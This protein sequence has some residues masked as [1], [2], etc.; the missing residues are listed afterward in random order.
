MGLLSDEFGPGV[1]PR[2]RRRTTVR[3]Y[4]IGPSGGQV[5]TLMI[6]AA[7]GGAV[8]MY[9]VPQ[10][11]SL[12]MGLFKGTETPKSVIEKVKIAANQKRNNTSTK[13]Q[14][15]TTKPKPQQ[16]QPQATMNLRRSNYTY[17]TRLPPLY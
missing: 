3:H 17:Y 13:P 16:Q 14:Q 8:A 9:Y 10:L 12:I 7:A 1:K 2:R 5:T 11:P 15:T 4:S 6:L